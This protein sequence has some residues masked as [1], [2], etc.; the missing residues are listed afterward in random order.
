MQQPEILV[1]SWPAVWRI[2]WPPILAFDDSNT[3]I[4]RDRLADRWQG[5]E[6]V[7]IV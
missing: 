7:P 2:Y 3:I 4:N 5:G 1:T 6:E